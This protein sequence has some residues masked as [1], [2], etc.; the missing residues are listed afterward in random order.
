[1]RQNPNAE[2]TT[3]E[4]QT[5]EM[6]ESGIERYNMMICNCLDD[7]LDRVGWNI[8]YSRG[9]DVSLFDGFPR[10]CKLYYPQNIVDIIMDKLDT[11]VQNEIFHLTHSSS[12]L[13]MTQQIAIFRFMARF[14][15]VA[16]MP[17][18]NSDRKLSGD[19]LAV[20]LFNFVMKEVSRYYSREK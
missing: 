4:A 17:W 12:K 1:L 7:L 6:M 5:A 3:L 13:D 10:E 18:M 2:N 11:S 19:S 16:A 8:L 9:G 20:R 15:L 14:V